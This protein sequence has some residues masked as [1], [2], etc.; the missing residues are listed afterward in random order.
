MWH[1]ASLCSWLG[2][3]GL[4]ALPLRIAL[5][6]SIKLQLGLKFGALAPQVKMTIA[7]ILCISCSKYSK[8]PPSTLLF[9][10]SPML[11]AN[12][13]IF[14]Q[15]NTRSLQLADPSDRFSKKTTPMTNCHPILWHARIWREKLSFPQQWLKGWFL[16]KSQCVLSVRSK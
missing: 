7:F 5:I 6:T 1:L 3:R 15:A 16:I 11:P 14:S 9:G 4:L 12:Y 13:L 2:R 8:Y 10:T